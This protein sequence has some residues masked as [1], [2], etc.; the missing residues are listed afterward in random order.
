MVATKQT[1]CVK[2]EVRSSVSLWVMLISQ[3]G[4]SLNLY[5]REDFSAVKGM[6]GLTDI[7]HPPPHPTRSQYVTT[8][9]TATGAVGHHVQTICC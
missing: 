4:H 5:A 3:R 8:L 1:T 9:K 2:H 7:V 6:L